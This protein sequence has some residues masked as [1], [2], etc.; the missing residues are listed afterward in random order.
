MLN[1]FTA[2]HDNK[3]FATMRIDIGNG[4]AKPLD[5]FSTTFLHG[6]TSFEFLF[7]ISV[8]LFFYADVASKKSL[9]LFSLL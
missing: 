8:F 1:G 6:K 7:V 9:F 4:V 3:R 2:Q 5:Q